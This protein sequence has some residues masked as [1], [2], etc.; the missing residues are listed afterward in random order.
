MAPN[1][2]PGTFLLL[3]IV[4]TLFFIHHVYSQN[5]STIV[6]SDFTSTT[7]VA[8]NNTT[9]DNFIVTSSSFSDLIENSTNLIDTSKPI[10]NSLSHSVSNSSVTCDPNTHFICDNATK[11]ISL[12]YRCDTKV[13]CKDESDEFDC[14]TK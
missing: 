3:S 14:P 13:D 6:S 4:Y 10:L 9:P 2:C 7:P 1:P 11:C 12:K 8:V 5:G